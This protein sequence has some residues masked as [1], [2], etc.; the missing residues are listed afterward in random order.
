METEQR[1]IPWGR[2]VG[3]LM[4]CIITLLGALF[5]MEPFEILQRAVM[6]A[7]LSGLIVRLT[8]AMVR[9][10]VTSEDGT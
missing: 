5:Q 3:L 1:P 9:V 10:A 6:A 7:I 2:T 8:I 4:A